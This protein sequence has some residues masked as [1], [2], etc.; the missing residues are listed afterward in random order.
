AEVG[1]IAQG[2]QRA[3]ARQ[4]NRQFLTGGGWVR[5]ADDR[6]VAV[7]NGWCG[8]YTVEYTGLGRPHVVTYC[9]RCSQTVDYLNRGDAGVD[10]QRDHRVD[11][12]GADVTDGRRNSIHQHLHATQAGG[13]S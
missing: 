1:G 10:A 4:I 5:S 7:E 3:K 13:E 11:L 9:V 12:A 8:S 6:I 2:V